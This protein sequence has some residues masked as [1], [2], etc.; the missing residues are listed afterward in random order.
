MSK[1]ITFDIPDNAALRWKTFA[2]AHGLRLDDAIRIA[3]ENAIRVW[4]REREAARARPR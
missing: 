2:D 4:D 1:T 3:V